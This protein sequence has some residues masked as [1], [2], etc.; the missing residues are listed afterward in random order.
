M[1]GLVGLIGLIGL[2]GLVGLVGL[3]GLMG[4][5]IT[6]CVAHDAQT[7]SHP[8]QSLAP[9]LRQPALATLPAGLLAPAGHFTGCEQPAHN[10]SSD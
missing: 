1:V 5:N 6:N 7:D 3:I 9:M 4:R 8:V 2:I 10:R